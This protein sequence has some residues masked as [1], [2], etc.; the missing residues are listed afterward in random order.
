QAI[1]RGGSDIHVVTG[2]ER[3]SVCFRLAGALHEHE[4]IPRDLSQSTVDRWKVLA[5]CTLTERQLPQEGRVLT[6]QGGKEFDLRVRVLPTVLGERGTVRILTRPGALPGRAQL[7]VA[8]R[9]PT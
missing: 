9:Q 2:N 4:S 3:T 8:P 5:D 1:G 7:A 6:T